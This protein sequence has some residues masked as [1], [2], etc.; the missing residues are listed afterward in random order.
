MVSIVIGIGSPVPMRYDIGKSKKGS[1]KSHLQWL[2]EFREKSVSKD[3]HILYSVYILYSPKIDKY[4][5]GYTG[6]ISKRLAYHNDI[7]RN[8]IWTRRGIPWELFF[9]I[10]YL[11]KNQAVIIEKKVKRMKSR[12]YLKN[13]T[14]YPEM[15]EKLKKQYG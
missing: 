1:K 10:D 6:D 2:F 9:Q 3:T 12:V 11:S 4:Y 5:I 15:V 13:L 14:R 7:L 8:R